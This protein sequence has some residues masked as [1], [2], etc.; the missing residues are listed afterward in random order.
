[1]LIP[2]LQVPGVYRLRGVLDRPVVRGVSVNSSATVTDLRRI[3]KSDLEAVLGKE[4]CRIARDISEV[5]QSVGEAR[6][7][8]ELFPFALLLVCALLF[9]EQ[10]MANR[11]YQWNLTGATKK[12]GGGQIA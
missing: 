9:G 11:F 2:N 1:L 10:W 5:E 12:S 4:N 6:Y 3:S 8:R 7:G